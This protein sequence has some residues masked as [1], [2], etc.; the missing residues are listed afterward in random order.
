M[1]KLFGGV[2]LLLEQDVI[3]NNFNKARATLEQTYA[4][5]ESDFLEAANLLPE[6]HSGSNVGRAHSGSAWGYLSKLYLYQERFEDAID[7][8]NRIING[9]YPLADSFEDNFKIATQYNPEI[10]FTIASSEGWQ[11]QTN[12][13]YTTP[14]PWG[15]WDFQAPLPN[16]VEEEFEENDPR[17][18]YSIMMPGDVFDLGG[19]RGMT[20]YTADLSPTTGYHFQKWAAWRDAGGLDLNMN[21]PMLRSADVYLLVAEAKIRSDGNGDAE[22]NAVRARASQDLPPVSNATMEDLIHERRVELAGESQRHFDLMRWDRAGIVD[23][24]AIY[25]EDR[26]PYDPTR[27]FVRPKHYFYAIP[28]NQIDVSDGVL[29]QNPGYE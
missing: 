15:G 11:T 5:I 27:T 21:L 9:P 26:G 2:P 7:A 29:E 19:D 14:R 12:T 3:D 23:I 4:Q 1:A 16:L 22:I 10:L 25:G 8:G 28:Q 18:D 13:I 6:Q 17:Q 24:V 20:E